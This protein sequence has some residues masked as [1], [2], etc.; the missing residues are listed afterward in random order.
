LQEIKALPH[1]NA[2]DGSPYYRTKS[3]TKV[4]MAKLAKTTK[5]AETCNKL[6]KE[7]GGV[8]DCEALEIYHE[9]AN[10]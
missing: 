1:G 9:I 7:A 6:L 4:K 2:K 5:P 3:S 8:S 10:K